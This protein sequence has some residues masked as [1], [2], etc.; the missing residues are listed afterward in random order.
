MRGFTL[1]EILVVI[2][3]TVILI[4]LAVPTYRF[5]QKESDLMNNTEKIINTLRL[6]QNK[7]LS[8]EGASQ[9]GVHLDQTTYTLFKGNNYIL[10]DDSFDEIHEFPESVEISEVILDG[11]G[12]EVIFD[13]ISGTTSQFGSLTIRLKDDIT[14]EKTI[15]IENSGRIGL[16]N[17]SVPSDAERIKDSRHVHLTY[18][19]DATTALALHLIF[20]DYP[21]DNYDIS[22]QD[23]LNPAITEFYWDGNIL[24]GPDGNKTEQKLKIH[25]HSLDMISSLFCVHRDQRHNDKALEITLDDQN[26]VKYKADGEPPPEAEKGD[27]IFVTGFQW[28]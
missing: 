6:S 20:P 5:F 21:A 12:S 11:G 13:R 24:V 10:R 7:T 17:P 19:Q 8:S 26:L 1:I 14:K 2:A 3:I 18:N 16:T 23:Y 9:Y 22:F 28:Q 15:Y 25:T 27:S 4:T